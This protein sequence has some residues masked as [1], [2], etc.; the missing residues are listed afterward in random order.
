MNKQEKNP[1]RLE[2]L[3]L[4]MGKYSLLQWNEEGLEKRSA[5]RFMIHP[6]WNQY[7]NDYNGDIALVQTDSPVQYSKSIR[8]ICLW[9]VGPDLSRVVGQTGIVAGWGNF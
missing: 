4:F 9:N 5:K 1:L 8:P 7:R 3:L 6:E 2:Y